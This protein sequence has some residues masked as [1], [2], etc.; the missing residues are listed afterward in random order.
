MIRKAAPYLLFALLFSAAGVTASAQT[1]SNFTGNWTMDFERSRLDPKSDVKG[2]S[3]KIAHDGPHLKINWAVDTGH[4]PQ[5]YTL[6]V[7]TDG[8]ESRQTVDGQ[9]CK[10]TAK[11]EDASGERMMIAS[12]CTGADGVSVL[13][14]H[15]LKLSN[16]GKMLTTTVMVKNAQGSMK[17]Y[18]FFTKE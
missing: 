2:A 7:Q 1:K 6:D 16:E 12:T 4:G 11:W 13:R 9:P 18:E 14:T 15:E 3:M 17:S 5:A 10:T 8:H